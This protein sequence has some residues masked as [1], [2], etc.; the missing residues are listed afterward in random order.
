MPTAVSAVTHAEDQ[1]S[2]APPTPTTMASMLRELDSIFESIS[3][4]TKD[5]FLL[6]KS[7]AAKMS[8]DA[9]V[10]EPEEVLM[11]QDVSLGGGPLAEEEGGAMERTKPSLDAELPDFL[12][13]DAP[14]D[15][16]DAPTIFEVCDAKEDGNAGGDVGEES[17][18]SEM[19]GASSYHME[20]QTDISSQVLEGL[21]SLSGFPSLTQQQQQLPHPN[22]TLARQTSVMTH[23][24]TQTL[25]SEPVGF[26]DNYFSHM[27]TQT[28]DDLFP[29]LMDCLA[30]VDADSMEDVIQC[31]DL[32]APHVLRIF[33]DDAPVT[34]H[35]YVACR[36]ATTTTTTTAPVTGHDAATL[37]QC[38]Q[39]TQQLRQQ[40]LQQR[41][42]P[43]MAP[44]D[45]RAPTGD[46]EGMTSTATTSTRRMNGMEDEEIMTA[47]SSL[48]DSQ[49]Q[50]YFHQMDFG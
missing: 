2:S 26:C 20:T 27:E 8:V 31:H 40:W 29:D 1:P 19:I 46:A 39:T 3:T 11:G 45:V 38:V 21:W 42:T 33:C 50:T 18:Q 6:E 22:A 9:S 49:T 13:D 4:Q 17:K 14:E 47:V 43:P 7:R 37:D 23:I 5:S 34:T 44:N 10:T 25:D 24:E 12:R 16:E 35:D 15:T 32:H 30:S 36:D 28:T 41:E 48:M